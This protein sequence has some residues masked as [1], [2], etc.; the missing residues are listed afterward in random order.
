MFSQNISTNIRNN[1][2]R[3]TTSYFTQFNRKKYTDSLYSH[4]NINF[5][6]SVQSS[7]AKR[8]SEFLA[9]RLCA[10]KCLSQ[11]DLSSQVFIGTHREPVWPD[12]VLGAIS[13][14]NNIAGALITKC[15]DYNGVGLDIENVMSN[16]TVHSISSQIMS[17]EELRYCNS[18]NANKNTIFTLIFSAKESFF[19]A[20]FSQVQKYFDFH[21]VK[22]LHI[23][24]NFLT[25]R[26]TEELSEVFQPGY[27]FSVSWGEID[28]QTILTYALL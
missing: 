25:F 24:E 22:I 7:V 27:E 26:V 11:Y 1:F 12:G 20:A 19:K 8:K 9:G 15:Q 2:P 23:S 10:K 28:T 21:A 3:I 16:E 14:T 6:A 18:C 17:K 13:H 4:Y 5:P